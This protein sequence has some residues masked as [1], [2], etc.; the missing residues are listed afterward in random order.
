MTFSGST[1]GSGGYKYSYDFNNSGT[2]EIT[3]STNPTATIPE[4]YVDSGPSTLVVHGRITDSSGNFTDYT[5][6]I[7]VND[8]APVPSI[9][10]PA[11]VVAGT[12][13]TF[14]ASATDPS[15]ADTAAGFTFAWTFGDGGT[16]TGASASHTYAAA[17]TYSVAVKATDTHG[18]STTTTASLVVNAALQATITGLPTQSNSGVAVT[19]KATV[20]GGATGT[21]TYSWVVT[22]G[23]VNFATGTGSSLAFTP[24]NSGAYLVALTVKDSAGNSAA[25][26]TS[27][28]VNDVAPTVTLNAPTSGTPGQSLSFSAAATDPSPAQT[29]AGFTYTWSFGD[30][31]TAIG[32]SVSHSYA[33]AAAYSV[34]VKA[35]AADGLTGTATASVAIATSAGAIPNEPLLYS[36]NVQYVGAFRVPEYPNVYGGASDELNYGGTALAFNP[37]NNSLFI[38]G[39]YQNIAEISIP[40]AIVNS[41]NLDAL[42]TDS[43][44][45]QMTPVLS[46]LP[47]QLTGASD[48]VDIGGL[49]VSNGELIG[50][51]YAYYSGVRRKRLRISC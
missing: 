50:T 29:A 51:A 30:G 41:S 39:H 48:G 24:G 12:A 33:A 18:L 7:T 40:S 14:K 49:M 43:Y 3:G 21:D 1:G 15:T 9:T 38:V 11:T 19:A 4:S 47:N 27:L 36:N 46:R 23:G 13:A 32:A 8:V 42:S 20:S 45:Q 28:T 2:F 5:T 26:S 10:L 16:A 35:T 44:L 22:T 17:G 31:T 37:A 25:A 6:S 34:S